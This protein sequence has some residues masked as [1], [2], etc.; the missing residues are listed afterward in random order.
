MGDNVR[1]IKSAGSRKAKRKVSA[2]EIFMKVVFT[3]CLE[4]A[5]IKT[6]VEETAIKDSNSR[7]VTYQPRSTKRVNKGR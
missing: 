3:N 6:S 1:T 4:K 2:V 5:I 7:L